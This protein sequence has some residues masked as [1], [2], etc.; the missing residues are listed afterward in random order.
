[1]TARRAGFLCVVPSHLMSSEVVPTALQS[2]SLYGDALASPVMASAV[3]DQGSE[4]HNGTA[5]TSPPSVV[6]Y[7]T[8]NKSS[9]LSPMLSKY[10]TIASPPCW[11]EFSCQLTARGLARVRPE[12]TWRSGAQGSAVEIEGVCESDDCCAPGPGVHGCL[13]QPLGT[14]DPRGHRYS[15]SPPLAPPS[16]TDTTSSHPKPSSATASSSSTTRAEPV[17]LSQSDGLSA[18]ASNFPSTCIYR[19]RQLKYS[20]S[21][22]FRRALRR[23]ALNRDVVV[24]NGPRFTDYVDHLGIERII[25]EMETDEEGTRETPDNRPDGAKRVSTGEDAEG[26]ADGWIEVTHR[27]RHRTNANEMAGKDDNRSRSPMCRGGR[28]IVNK[29]LRESRMPRLPR[30][31]IKIIVRP[32]DGL[33]IRNTCGMS[34][35]E[36]IRKEAVVGDD[37]KITICPNPTQSILVISTPDETTATKIA[38]IK[39]L[40]INGKRHET[41]AYVSAPEQMVKGIIRNIPLKYTQDQLTHALVNSR[42]PSLAYAKRLGSTTTV[43]LLYEGNRVPTWAYFNSIMIRVSLY[44]KQIDFCKECGR[45]GHRPDVCPRPEIKL[46]PTC[47]SKNPR[48]EPECT[49]K[50]RICGEAHPTA[51]RM[52]K[53][54][55]KLPHIV[56]QRRWRARSRAEMERTLE[57]GKTT[58]QRTLSPSG[59]SRAE[60][61][62][63][64]RSRSRSLTPIRRRSRSHNRRKSRSRSRSRSRSG[65]GNRNRNRPLPDGVR[66]TQGETQTGPRKVTW[67]DI[68]AGRNGYCVEST[69]A[70]GSTRGAPDRLLAA[71]MEKMERENKELRE[72]LGRD[73]KQNEQSARKIDELQQTLNEI[74]KNMKGSSHERISSSTSREAAERGDVTATEG[75]VG[76]MDT[77]CGEEAPATAG[78]KRK[79][80]S[81][82]PP[83]ED[84]VVHAQAP[85]RPRSGARKIDAIEEM[86]NKLTDK[87]ERMFD[88]LLTR[89]N[90]SDAGRNAQCAAVNTQLAAMNK[91]IED[92]ERGTMQLQHQQHHHHLP[93][94]AGVPSPQGIN[95]PAILTSGNNANTT[96]TG[97]GGMHGQLCPPNTS[98]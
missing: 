19:S 12:T 28:S 98:A 69:P 43:I 93:G 36:A 96:R 26:V 75:E 76:E 88:M 70:T 27:R 85:K 50:C 21:A 90:E 44:R 23:S 37:E 84:A 10:N 49:P 22:K 56:K 2:E 20:C 87:T 1:M 7:C 33:N 74:L 39:V 18:R 89:L 8:S 35:D 34:L 11:P 73:R 97:E 79:G 14:L 53:A 86:V 91:R 41:N 16:A 48:S 95:V 24:S 38:M 6:A 64:S 67:S 77:C 4:P 66:P 71:R 31:D 29:V 57:D 47:G 17:P 32:K 59:Y 9:V 80:T 60:G 46:C 55:Y 68:V 65:S 3:H 72:E 63:Q 40:T 58:P 42:N 54:K 78:S 52:C 94:R 5:G 83:T 30:D 25:T 13:G 15:L 62:G 82:A 92:L 81:D 61:K 45:L 51:D